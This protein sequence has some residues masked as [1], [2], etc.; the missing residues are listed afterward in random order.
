VG[1]MRKSGSNITKKHCIFHG[2][3]TPKWAALQRTNV[4]TLGGV[5]GIRMHRQHLGIPILDLMYL[6]AGEEY[7]TLQ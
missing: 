2:V 3:T 1:K 6:T 7:K 5:A 4:C